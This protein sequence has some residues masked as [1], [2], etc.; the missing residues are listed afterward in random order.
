MQD[1]AKQDTRTLEAHGIINPTKVWWNQTTAALYEHSLR[2]GESNIARL[3]PL[4]V[5][6][7]KYTGR[8]PNDRF[9][10]REPSCEDKIW[11]GKINVEFDIDKYESLR[12]QLT[13]YLQICR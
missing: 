6:T 4:V 2:R 5:S 10:V 9:V 13:G 1:Q 8:S 11:W 7:G 3:G 12:R